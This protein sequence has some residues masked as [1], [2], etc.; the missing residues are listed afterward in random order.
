MFLGSL[1]KLNRSLQTNILSHLL[2]FSRLLLH[3]KFTSALLPLATEPADEKYSSSIIRP[4]ATRVCINRTP[5]I[6][7]TVLSLIFLPRTSMRCLAIV[8]GPL[9]IQKFASNSRDSEGQFLFFVFVSMWSALGNHAKRLT[10][11]AG[12]FVH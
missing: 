4:R 7:S 8:T 5:F 3:A 2:S 11:L 10:K 1:P 9:S 12:Q 6:F